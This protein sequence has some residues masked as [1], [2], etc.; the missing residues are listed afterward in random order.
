[1]VIVGQDLG[2]EIYLEV[3][4]CRSLLGHPPAALPPRDHGVF[5]QDLLGDIAMSHR[6]LG[7]SLSCGFKLRNL[8]GKGSINYRL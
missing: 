6:S 2:Q 4:G 8:S 1:M 5:S 7:Q 3:L